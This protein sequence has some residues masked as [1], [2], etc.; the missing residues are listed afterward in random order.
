MKWIALMLCCS[1]HEIK[2]NATKDHYEA[3][4]TRD[5]L[6]FFSHRALYTMNSIEAFR[7][8]YQ[9]SQLS[10]ELV[11]RKHLHTSIVVNQA[12]NWLRSMDGTRFQLS[13]GNASSITDQVVSLIGDMYYGSSEVQALELTVAP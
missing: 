1:Q 11:L 5:D 7:V 13:K 12:D 4:Q 9:T 2:T 6:L 3:I 8:P 10:L